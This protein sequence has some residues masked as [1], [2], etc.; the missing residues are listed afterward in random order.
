ML[1]T[2]RTADLGVS[3]LANKLASTRFWAAP[4]NALA[5]QPGFLP[6]AKHPPLHFFPNLNCALQLYI[7]IVPDK[8]NN[9]LSII[10]S[11]IGMTKVRIRPR[12]AAWRLPI[13][14]PLRR[15][16]FVPPFGGTRYALAM[17]APR[18]RRKRVPW[19]FLD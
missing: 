18:T 2:R 4:R 19:A 1:R 14:L 3:P 10:D 13:K 11:G 17:H 8:T 5:L 15:P 12:L 7:H 9:T 16:A 6:P